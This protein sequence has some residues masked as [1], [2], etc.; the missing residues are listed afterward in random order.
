MVWN[1]GNKEFDLER[2]VTAQEIAYPIALDEMRSGQKTNH[3]IWYI[4]PQQKGLGHSYN[5]EYY[6]IDG[7][8]EARAYLAHPI[9]GARLREISEALLNHKGQRDIDA[10][11]GSNIDVL[12]LQTCMN[13]FNRVSPNDIFEKVLDAFF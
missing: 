2:F 4:F 5:S 11:M 13:L 7:I 1:H 9:L 8:D 12:K 6:G 3:W 10:I